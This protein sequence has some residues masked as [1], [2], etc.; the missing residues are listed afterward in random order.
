MTTKYTTSES[1]GSEYLI[2]TRQLMARTTKGEGNSHD[3]G[4]NDLSIAGPTM[5]H[6]EHKMKTLDRW[7]TALCK[8]I[9][10]EHADEYND[11]D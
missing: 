8:F 4:G 10:R 6:V 3:D 2:N 7:F 5:F 1:G 11:D 9:D